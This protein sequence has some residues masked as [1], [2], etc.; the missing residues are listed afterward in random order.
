[1]LPNNNEQLINIL[2][3]NK[4]CYDNQIYFVKGSDLQKSKQKQSE[5]NYFEKNNQQEQTQVNISDQAQQINQSNVEVKNSSVVCKKN[6]IMAKIYFQSFILIL[7]LLTLLSPIYFPIF[8]IGIGIIISQQNDSL[9]NGAKYIFIFIIFLKFSMTCFFYTYVAYLSFI[10]ND[11]NNTHFYGINALTFT[12]Q[13][14]SISIITGM[15]IFIQNFLHFKQFFD[16]K[17]AL[18]QIEIPCDQLYFETIDRC[19]ISGFLHSYHLEK[20]FQ[21]K[22]LQ[23]LKHEKIS[24]SLEFNDEQKS[25]TIIQ[26]AWNQGFYLLHKEQERESNYFVFTS[27]YQYILYGISFI[28]MAIHFIL[29]IVYLSDKSEG[30]FDRWNCALIVFCNTSFVGIFFLNTIMQ[31]MTQEAFSKVETIA[32][33]IEIRGFMPDHDFVKNIPT[34][35]LY[36]ITSI[37]TW[38]YMRQL[39][40]NINQS[41]LRFA[42]IL[43]CIEVICFLTLSTILVM[44]FLGIGWNSNQIYNNKLLLGLMLTNIIMRLLLSLTPIFINFSYVNNIL[45]YNKEQIYSIYIRLNN[46]LSNY[47]A[48]RDSWSTQL[49]DIKIEHYSDVMNDQNQLENALLDTKNCRLNDCLSW[50]KIEQLR[51]VY[52]VQRNTELF[53]SSKLNNQ[54]T[55]IQLS[56]EE[57]ISREIDYLSTLIKSYK[58]IFQDM[59]IQEDKHLLK[60]LGIIPISYAKAQALLIILLPAV[61]SIIMQRLQK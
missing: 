48:I 32:S 31:L 60:F 19:N 25:S 59:S 53:Y 36:C 55:Y 51:V 14:Y 54:K 29:P 58:L 42:N 41:F 28:C 38:F 34:I 9:T 21:T 33:L 43:Q 11:E 61:F 2:I 12:G 5:L 47:R 49:K 26:K 56:E 40:L 7:F 52:E 20:I 37:K 13:L 23:Q 16:I 10:K 1:M 30:D 44:D 6:T 27:I 57:K 4:L 50:H 18:G 35:N 17:S 22:F 3:L 46:I 24:K 8:S 45:K 15:F 39:I